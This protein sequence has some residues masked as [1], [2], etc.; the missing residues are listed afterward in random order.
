MEQERRRGK[1]GY[2][3]GVKVLTCYRKRS[4]G[5]GVSLPLSRVQ[6]E[7]MMTAKDKRIR[8]T[9]GREKDPRPEIYLTPGCGKELT[10]DTVK[11]SEIFSNGRLSRSRKEVGRLRVLER[12][13]QRWVLELERYRVHGRVVLGRVPICTSEKKSAVL[14]NKS[15]KHADGRELRQDINW[16]DAKENNSVEKVY[17]QRITRNKV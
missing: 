14:A 6:R 11:L 13:R 10:G 15:A 7:V 1:H 4:K 12:S 16:I 17:D 3:P 5:W 2:Q 8:Q 9:G